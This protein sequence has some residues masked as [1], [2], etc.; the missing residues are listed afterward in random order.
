MMMF[1]WIFVWKNG[2]NNMMDKTKPNL[3]ASVA[4]K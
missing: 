2:Q 3:S 4:D 1:A